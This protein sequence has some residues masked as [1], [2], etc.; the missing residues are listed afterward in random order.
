MKKIK[1]TLGIV[2]FITLFTISCNKDF[3][4][5]QP[6]DKISSNATW[7]DGALA[8]AFVNNQYS[9]FGLCILK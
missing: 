9:F 6:L 4:D 8:E 3:L 7:A 1:I 5:T 2:S